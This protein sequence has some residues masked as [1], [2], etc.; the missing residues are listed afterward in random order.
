MITFQNESNPMLF[1]TCD[2]CCKIFL[3]FMKIC[4]G[5]M[6]MSECCASEVVKIL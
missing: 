5:Y 3:R 2:A 6:W 1:L 4:T